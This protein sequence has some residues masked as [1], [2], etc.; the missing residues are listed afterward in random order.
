MKTKTTKKAITGSVTG[1]ALRSPHRIVTTNGIRSRDNRRKKSFVPKRAKLKIIPL[2]GLDEIGK[3]MMI[4]EYDDPYLPNGGDI[5]IVDMGFAFPEDEM[6]G[7]DYVIPDISYLQDKKDKIRGIVITHGHEDH[8]GGIPYLLPKI[9]VPVF[10]TKLTAGLIEKKLQEFKL[11][12]DKRV[13]VIDPEETLRLGVFRI[14]FFRV[15]HSIPDGVGLAIHTPYGLVI[16]TGDFKLDPTPIDG[17]V[18]ELDKIERIC[19]QSGG[20]LMLLSDSTNAEEPGYTLS[21][22]VIGEAFESV[23]NQARGRIVIASF[24]S[25]V[26]RIQQVIWSAEKFGRK[27]AISG[28]SMQENIEVA[29]KLGYLKVPEGL[30]VSLRDLKKY[31][32]DRIVI[33]STG[34]QGEPSSALV[35]MAAGEHAQVAIKKGDTVIISASPIPGNERSITN[36]IDDLLRRGARVVYDKTMRVHVTGHACQDELA[37]MIQV[38]KPKYFIPIHGEYHHLTAHRNLAIENGIR[39]DNAFVIEDGQMVEIDDKG[40]RIS[41]RRIPTGLVMVDGLGVGDIGNIVLRDRQAMAQ[42]GIFVLIVTVDKKKGELA[43]SPDIISR[44]FVY[45]RESEKLIHGARA[46]IKRIF[47]RHQERDPFNW[48]AVKEV[49]KEEIG[50]YLYKNTKRRPM[51]IPVVIEV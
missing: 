34:S 36:T 20:A 2:G 50:D 43:S 23:F 31:P 19:R 8:V 16:H 17:K 18:T 35:R 9:D 7:I 21:E 26:A 40:A 51:V 13:S 15:A 4:F 49:L 38:V 6:Y 44:G 12:R 37:K 48:K 45:M 3:N 1:K 22:K 39:E 46:E 5:I 32:D 30:I 47:A 25:L 11:L 29:I 42:D 33:I 28:R 14:E 41:S 24:A 27:V 10:A